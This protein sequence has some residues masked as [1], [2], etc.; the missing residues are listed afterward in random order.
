MSEDVSEPP[1]R[2]VLSDEQWARMTELVRR[3]PTAA[4]YGQP[5]PTFREK[6]M[7]SRAVDLPLRRGGR[8]V[9]ISPSRQI[10]DWFIRYER[11]TSLEAFFDRQRQ[12][13]AGT[14][15]RDH[16][17]RISGY[18]DSKGQHWWIHWAWP[19][20]PAPPD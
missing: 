17:G 18:Y 3:I 9:D 8:A 19:E 20:P 15:S 5:E 2:A 6:V 1:R 10:N 13:L 12:R 14:F 7:R 16:E 4:D 11:R